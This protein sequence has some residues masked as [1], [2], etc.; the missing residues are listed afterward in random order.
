MRIGLIA[1]PWVAVPP[2]GYGGTEAV[3]AQL[4]V[5]LQAAGHDVLLAASSDS[6]CAVERIGGTAPS[7]PDT[8]SMVFPE[9]RH[10]ALA[11]SA[12]EE[13]ELDVVHDHTTVG[14]VYRHRNARVPVVTTAHGAFDDAALDIYRS[15]ARDV[16]I[17][18]ISRR[19]AETAHGIPIAAVIHHGLDASAI[20]VG[21]GGGG[22][23]CFLGRMDPTKGIVDAIRIARRA[24]VPLRMAAKMRSAAEHEYFDAVVRPE[25]GPDVEFMGEI[26]EAEKYALLGGA[27]IL[28][29]PM[30]WEEPFGMVMIES[31]VTGTPVAASR[32]G[33]APEIIDHGSTGFLCGTEEEFVAAVGRAAELDRA[34]CRIAVQERFSARLMADRYAELYGEVI[35]AR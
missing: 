15:I 8:I 27:L 3:V 16:A 25:L 28:L 9:V 7:D 5:S 18:A 22:Y 34:R 14:P 10:V 26:G 13:L 32:R 20:P 29:D 33:S 31:L 6:T 2:V 12:F 23:A 1:P 11:Y 30:R 19:Q 17:V 24:G 21:P 4:A 35:A